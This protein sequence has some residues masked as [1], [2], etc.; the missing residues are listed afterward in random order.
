MLTPA[1]ESEAPQVLGVRVERHED[2]A[3]Q[4]QAFHQNP[5]VVGGQEV[6]EQQDCD[7]AS[8]LV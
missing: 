7:L 8:Y 5:I 3:V 1:N 2:E 4:I 6:D